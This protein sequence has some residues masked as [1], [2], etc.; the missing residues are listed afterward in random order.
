MLH[1][2]QRDDRGEGPALK[3]RLIALA[4][5][6]VAAAP[7]RIDSQATAAFRAAFG[8]NGSA[9]L[10]RQGEYKETIK[11]T[12][13]ALVNAPFGPVLVS[14]GEVL[15]ASHASSGKIAAIYMRRMPQGYAV[16]KRFIPAMETGSFGSIG[17]WRVSHTF[18]T[19]PIVTVEG[20]GT[21]QGYTCSVMTLLELAADKPRELVTVPLYY[22]DGGAVMPPQRATEVTGRI[23]NIVSGRSFDVVYSG[24]KHFTERYL[25]RGNKYVVARGKSRMPTC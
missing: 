16:D 11:Y 12:P 21:W 8:K 17:K 22:S 20:G 19:M 14:L 18:G 13:G 1:R 24:S 7:A 9:I 3:L 6:A 23:T 15:D 2:Q 5:L 25:R 10:K 4:L